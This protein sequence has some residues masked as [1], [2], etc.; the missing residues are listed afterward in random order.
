MRDSFETLLLPRPV[1]QTVCVHGC[2][3]RYYGSVSACAT[4]PEVCEHGGVARACR[5]PH[6]VGPGRVSA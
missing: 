3:V 2:P 5:L 1:L 4:H 6:V